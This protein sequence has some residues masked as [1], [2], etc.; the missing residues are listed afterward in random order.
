MSDKKYTLLVID[1][2]AALNTALCESLKHAG[3]AVK[4]A[5][6][7]SEGLKEVS[8]DIDLVLLDVMLTDTTGW[9]VLEEIKSE[10]STKDIPVI[11]MSNLDST[12]RRVELSISGAVDYILKS[13]TS[14]D[15]IVEKVNSILKR[16]SKTK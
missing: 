3:Y 7:G 9:D 6:T 13:N 10:A 1:D 4:S 5:R 14:L 15:T 2:E 12:D 16:S 8:H 11:V